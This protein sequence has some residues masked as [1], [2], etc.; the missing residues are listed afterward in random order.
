MLDNKFY[1]IINIKEE[2]YE[3][4]GIIKNQLYAQS[5]LSWYIVSFQALTTQFKSH[6]FW[7]PDSKKIF[8]VFG[9]QNQ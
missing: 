9:V 7:N 2:I 1:A 4:K 3:Y 6:I 8:K 5:H